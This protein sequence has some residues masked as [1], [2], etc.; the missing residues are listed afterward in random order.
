M[1]IRRGVITVVRSGDVIDVIV[2]VLQIVGLVE[3]V[4]D[5]CTLERGLVCAHGRYVLWFEF[6][7]DGFCDG[8]CI[9]WVLADSWEF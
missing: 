1:V 2:V 3:I 8:T 6:I 5:W 7:K 4:A 9:P